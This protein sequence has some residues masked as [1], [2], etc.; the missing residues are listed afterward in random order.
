VLLRADDFFFRLD[1]GTFVVGFCAG[2][3]EVDRAG[4]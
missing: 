3:G 4:A 2:A 1:F